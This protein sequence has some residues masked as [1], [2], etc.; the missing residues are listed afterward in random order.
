MRG[1]H[2][3]LRQKPTSLFMEASHM[4]P[5]ET[6]RTWRQIYKVTRS[7]TCGNQPQGQWIYTHPIALPFPPS[8][9]IPV[10]ASHLLTSTDPSPP[11]PLYLFPCSQEILKMVYCAY[12][13]S[14][15]TYGIIFWGNSCQSDLIFRLFVCD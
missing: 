15:M 6:S 13:H 8:D 10:L 12:F 9:F 7:C 11:P 2:Q 3:L 5:Q 14:I 4:L 1:F